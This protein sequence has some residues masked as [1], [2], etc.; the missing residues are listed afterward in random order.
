MKGFWLSCNVFFSKCNASAHQA[1]KLFKCMWWIQRP[2][3][4]LKAEFVCATDHK[5]RP[6]AREC[7]EAKPQF[8]I[9]WETS[10][11]IFYS[12]SS[13]HSP[14]F[15]FFVVM[16]LQPFRVRLNLSYSFW[17]WNVGKVCMLWSTYLASCIYFFSFFSLHFHRYAIYLSC[18]IPPIL[19]AFSLIFFFEILSKRTQEITENNW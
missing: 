17:S 15:C 9:P 11:H 6:F 3:G 8:Q 5:S 18:F 16:L 13:I 12:G 19:L 10:Q 4:Y 7:N 1:E 2:C 14:V